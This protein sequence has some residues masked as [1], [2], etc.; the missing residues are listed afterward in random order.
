MDLLV[1][2]VCV[3]CE[4]WW[5]CLFFISF[6]LPQ[7]RHTTLS[8]GIARPEPESS[9]QPAS[10]HFATYKSYK[11]IGS[12]AL[13]SCN[14]RPTVGLAIH[15]KIKA[16]TNKHEGR[17]IEI[18]RDLSKRWRIGE[19]GGRVPR[20]HRANG[21]LPGLTECGNQLLMAD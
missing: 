17:A 18:A 14:S 21:W 8:H 9:L 6:P 4:G 12:V 11:S 10:G 16:G 15:L 20:K 7:A 2:S 3:C 5:C 1:V 13:P 19:A